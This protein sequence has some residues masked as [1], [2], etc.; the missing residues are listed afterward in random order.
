MS[1]FP[2]SAVRN[3][4]ASPDSHLTEMLLEGIS[5]SPLLRNAVYC[6]AAPPHEVIN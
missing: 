2:R 1:S 5:V 6:V 4:A 3:S